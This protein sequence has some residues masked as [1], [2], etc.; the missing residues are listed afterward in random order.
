MNSRRLTPATFVMTGGSRI[1]KTTPKRAPRPP[2][3]G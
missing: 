2:C 1:Y 3:Q